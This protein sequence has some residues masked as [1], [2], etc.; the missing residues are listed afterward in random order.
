MKPKD[1]GATKRSSR[2][3]KL[4]WAGAI[5]VAVLALGAVLW[6][7]R[8][9][10]YTPA[11]A[12]KDLKA[13]FAAR[14]APVPA[15]KFLELRYGPQTE[16]T[17]RTAAFIDLFNSGHIE[18]LYLIVGNRSDEGTRKGIEDVA[19]ILRDH[20]R[21]MTPDEKKALANYFS[22]DA[23]K[24]QIQ[25]ATGSYQSKDARFRAVAAPVIQELMTTLAA[26]QEH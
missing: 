12:V 22:S 16:A 23:G 5:A 17:N 8:F 11:E 3:K 24:T 14:H 25:A 9:H 10:D 13:G 19:Q 20:R 15:R 7:R 2:G 4:L 21:D 26:L 6:V 1:Q 18:G